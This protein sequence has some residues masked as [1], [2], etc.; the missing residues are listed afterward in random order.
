MITLFFRAV[1]K[2]G[3]CRQ[4]TKIE[5]L[6]TCRS[7]K[8][9][10]W[11]RYSPRVLDTEKA[12]IFLGK[13]LK[14]ASSRSILTQRKYNVISKVNEKIM[15]LSNNTSGKCYEN[16]LYSKKL[17][18]TFSIFY[19]EIVVTWTDKANG[20]VVFLCQQLYAL[21]IIN[22]FCLDQNTNSTNKIYFQLHKTVNEVISD[23]TTFL[24]KYIWFRSHRTKEEIFYHILDT[25][26]YIHTSKFRFIIAASQSLVKP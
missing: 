11:G 20:N 3:F 25:K 9:S 13:R 16:V 1:V 10:N 12:L 7:K 17:L 2:V 14:Q 23:Q 18:P 22:E 21:V 8:I 4:I 24:T 15:I 5:L 19:Y 26:L 6:V